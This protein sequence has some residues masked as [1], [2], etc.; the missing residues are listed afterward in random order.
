MRG[1]RLL[2]LVAL[3]TGCL[4]ATTPGDVHVPPPELHAF[5]Y[6]F[7]VRVTEV[8]AARTAPVSLPDNGSCV[9][10]NS[11]DTQVLGGLARATW[12]ASSPATQ[13]L[14]LG[15]IDP[16]DASHQRAVNGSS[17]LSIALNQTHLAPQSVLIAY[18]GIA[19]GTGASVQQDAKLA[20]NFTYTG[21]DP[22]VVNAS[23]KVAIGN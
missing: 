14:A 2:A 13:T 9:S 4:N 17:P 22:R 6:T 20:L 12:T 1:L 5:A 19:G 3:A 7:D 8:F 11:N 15:L 16:R 21:L 23:C 10:L 18:L